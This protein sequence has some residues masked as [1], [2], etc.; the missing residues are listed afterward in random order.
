MT[1]PRPLH[2]GDDGEQESGQEERHDG[3]IDPRLPTIMTA[4]AAPPT[5]VLLFQGE[6]MTNIAPAGQKSSMGSMY[7]AR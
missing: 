1:V 3:L 2:L 7:S 6:R 5:M 4:Q